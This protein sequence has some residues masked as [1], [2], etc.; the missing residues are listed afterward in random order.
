MVTPGLLVPATH[1][2]R[3]ETNNATAERIASEDTVISTATT[4]SAT[5]T[6]TTNE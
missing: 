1:S 2:V 4:T 5:F 3:T 6:A